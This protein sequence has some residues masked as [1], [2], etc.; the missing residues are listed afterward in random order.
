[1]GRE[2]RCRRCGDVAGKHRVPGARQASWRPIRGW[3]RLRPFDL[4]G[5]EAAGRKSLTLCPTCLRDLFQWLDQSRETALPPPEA[6]AEVEVDA[7]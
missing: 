2:I 5:R 3:I 7:G 4:Q 6:G 1:M